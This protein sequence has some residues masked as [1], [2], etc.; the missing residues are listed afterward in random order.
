VGN[1]LTVKRRMKPERVIFLKHCS[2]NIHPPA[3]QQEIT[4]TDVID[5]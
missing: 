5:A 3:Q 2:A 1:L 4:P